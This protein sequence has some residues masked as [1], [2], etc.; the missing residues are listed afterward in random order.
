M[1]VPYQCRV[2]LQSLIH[3]NKTISSVQNAF[4]QQTP[5][6]T[7]ISMTWRTVH[8]YRVPEAT[9]NQKLD[10]TT[11]YSVPLKL[12][13]MIL[14]PQKDRIAKVSGPPHD[15]TNKMACAPSEDSDQPWHSPSFISL[16]CPPEGSLG[17]KLPF[18]RP[19]KTLIRL[20]GCPG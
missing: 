20:G 10:K 1:F 4:Y 13:P 6:Q 7:A 16:R 17:P 11:A 15:K 3:S 5:A 19:S 8:V 9:T 2:P 14:H 12:R 18:E